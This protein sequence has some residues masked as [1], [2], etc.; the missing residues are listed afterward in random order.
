MGRSDH[1]FIRHY[2]GNRGCF[3][4]LRRLICLS[5][6]GASAHHQVLCPTALLRGC[7]A[8]RLFRT[9]V[10]L[11]QIASPC[12]CTSRWSRTVH[13]FLK[14]TNTGAPFRRR[15]AVSKT[16]LSAFALGSQGNP[17]I[18]PLPRADCGPLRQRERGP[19]SRARRDSQGKATCFF[20]GLA[21]ALP[22]CQCLRESKAPVL[23]RM[24]H[25]PP[26]GGEA[27]T[28]SHSTSTP[29]CLFC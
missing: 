8:P 5:W 21:H 4:F 18:P 28:V 11:C 6:A 10:S 22:L 13:R 16:R 17:M 29:Q 19:L 7:G 20:S 23:R 27:N 9:A 25:A 14:S 26:T 2:C 12:G 3:S 24:T 1:H 15:S